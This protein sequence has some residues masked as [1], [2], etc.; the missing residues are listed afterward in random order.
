[1]AGDI[2]FTFFHNQ[3]AANPMILARSFKLFST[4]ALLA[5][6]PTYGK[7][8]DLEKAINSLVESERSY[9][10][11]ALEKDFRAASL[12]VFTDDAVI[13]AP[14]PQSAR[15]YWEKETEIPFLIWRPTFASIA[16]SADLGY[17][18]GP[19]E[20]KKSR[21]DEKP[22]AFGSFITIW[23]RLADGGWRVSLDVGTEHP[24]PKEPAGEVETFVPDFAIARLESVRQRLEDAEKNFTESLAREAGAAVLAKAGDDIRIYRRGA[25]PAVGKTAA[26][27]MLSFDQEKQTRERAGSGLS[28]S[29]DLA[30]DYGEYSSEYANITEHGTY[31]SIWQLDLSSEWRLMLDLQKKCRPGKSKI[32]VV[33]SVFQT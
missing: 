16:R 28:R 26:K 7:D 9:A 33:I 19:W 11:L 15:K 20:Y 18:T 27:L 29:A 10:K 17:T 31:L 22:Q 2:L 8:L 3:K 4:S 25:V 1:M 30:Y 5:L 12:Q 13:F 21:D 32:D 14:G 6:A 23:K 24:K